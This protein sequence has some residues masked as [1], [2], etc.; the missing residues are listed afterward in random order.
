MACYLDRNLWWMFIHI[1]SMPW[2]QEFWRQKESRYSWSVLIK[3]QVNVI[4]LLKSG[5]PAHREPHL[6]ILY[7][8]KPVTLIVTHFGSTTMGFKPLIVWNIWPVSYNLHI[9]KPT[10]VDSSAETERWKQKRKKGHYKVLGALESSN[11]A[12]GGPWTETNL[13]PKL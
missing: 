8:T 4:G 12:V 10:A 2:R 1:E 7:R 5:R 9:K 3:W 13:A 6:Q 11:W